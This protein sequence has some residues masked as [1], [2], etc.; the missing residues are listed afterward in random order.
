M[1]DQV[2]AYNQTTHKM[3]L[4]PVQH[5]WINHDNDLV[6]LTIQPQATTVPQASQKDTKA[7]TIHTTRKHPFL[8]V[9]HGFL[10]ANA[11]KPGMHVIEANG[12]IRM[13]TKKQTKKISFDNSTIKLSNTILI[14]LLRCS[15]IWGSILSSD[16]QN[17]STSEPH[18]RGI[19]MSIRS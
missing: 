3:E 2:W 6:D 8:T 16:K 4:E 17:R 9:E 1:G 11:L 7:E 13:V 10:P 19:E 15:N 14:Y 5:V 18:V 12:H